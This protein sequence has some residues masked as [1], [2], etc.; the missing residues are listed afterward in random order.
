LFPVREN[1]DCMGY[2]MVTVKINFQAQKGFDKAGPAC[3][4]EFHFEKRKYYD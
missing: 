4:F 1:P 2:V 3:I